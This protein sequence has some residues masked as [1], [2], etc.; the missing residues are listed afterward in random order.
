MAF[1]VR[2]S[3]GVSLIDNKRRFLCP[4]NHEEHVIIY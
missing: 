2:D 3:E 4:L 1:S